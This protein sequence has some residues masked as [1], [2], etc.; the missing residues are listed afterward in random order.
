MARALPHG[1]EYRR[2]EPES[3]LLYRTVAAEIDALRAEL[4]AASPHGAALPAH[5]DREIEAYLRCGILRH[6]FARVVCKAC[7]AEHLVA[8]SCK[9]RGICPSCTTRRMHDTAAHLVDRVLPR[10]PMRQ[11]VATF[12]RR[13]R[14]HLAA[15]PRLAT[16]ANREVLRALFAWQRRRARR[17]GERPDRAHSNGAVTFVQRFNSALELSLHFHILVPDGVFV[18]DHPDLDARP[19]F[20]RLPAPPATRWPS[21]STSSLPD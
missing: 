1:E 9:G 18:R 8:W 10:V 21:C 14:W 15:D 19:R 7:R 2:R 12:P 13:V 20:V 17:L 11:W 16:L 6:G 3:T 4:A 5:V